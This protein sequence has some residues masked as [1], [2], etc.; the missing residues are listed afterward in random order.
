MRAALVLALTLSLAADAHAKCARVE[1]VVKPI[2]PAN[3]PIAYGGGIVVGLTYG[4]ERGDDKVEQPTWRIKQGG[5]LTAPRIKILAP[6]LATYEIAGEGTLVDA[7]GKSLVAV[8]NGT[9]LLDLAV[10]VLKSA[11]G[12]YDDGVNEKWGASSMLQLEVADV[13]ANTIGLIV[14]QNDK[15]IHW[16]TFEGKS[17]TLTFRAGG[18]C[19]NDLPGTSVPTR[20]VITV[21][22]F[23]SSGRVS[24]VSKA[25]AIKEVKK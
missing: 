15:A 25:L 22:Y 2:T 16:A 18:H 13:P 10:P 19:S 24:P 5:K 3:T 21:S 7:K 11:V 9:K 23:D 17:H 20:G 12:T 8:K 4:R 6:G 14:H 1:I